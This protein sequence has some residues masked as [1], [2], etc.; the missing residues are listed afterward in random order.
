M[1]VEITKLATINQKT[2]MAN[3]DAVITS[4]ISAIE[5]LLRKCHQNETS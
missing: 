5:L 1:T 3:Y 4:R 2:K